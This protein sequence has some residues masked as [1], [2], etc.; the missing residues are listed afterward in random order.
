MKPTF[1]PLKIHYLRQNKKCDESHSPKSWRKRSGR[2]TIRALGKGLA[3]TLYDRRIKVDTPLTG[4]QAFMLNGLLDSEIA[5]LN[6]FLLKT[7]EQWHRDIVTSNLYLMLDTKKILIPIAKKWLEEGSLATGLESD[8][9][10]NERLA[11]KTQG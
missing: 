5:R 11:L 10:F 8:K 3:L 6:Q 4:S 7:E 2:A 1:N 9:K